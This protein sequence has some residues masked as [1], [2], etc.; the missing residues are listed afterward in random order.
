MQEY[1]KLAKLAE[2]EVDKLQLA[3]V[4]AKNIK[5]E[6]D[7]K[8]ATEFLIKVK[9]VSKAIFAKKNPI[10]KSL[11]EALRE[12]R[13]LFKPAEDRLDKAE[14]QVKASILNY[15]QKIEE[16]ALRAAQ[17]IEK[18]VDDGK[19]KLSTGMGKISKIEQ[20]SQTIQTKSGSAQFRTIKR[21]RIIDISKLKV[22]MMRPRVQEAIRMEVAE[23]VRKGM[24]VPDG[25]EIYDKKVVAGVGGQNG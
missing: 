9:T 22:Y 5:N 21:V 4:K 6:D 8:R 24:S 20:G 10:V 14:M 25:A 17:S 7:L 15:N 2:K 12:V 19:M 1:S 11:N 18:K 13:G 3:L 16:K 23:D